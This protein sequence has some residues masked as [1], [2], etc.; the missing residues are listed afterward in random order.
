MLGDVSKSW[1]PVSHPGTGSAVP[2]HLSGI[3]SPIQFPS[4][5]TLEENVEVYGDR[6]SGLIATL[7]HGK[8]TS[9]IIHMYST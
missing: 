1:C 7:S 4:C 6:I 5:G 2:E 3:P 9:C 8:P